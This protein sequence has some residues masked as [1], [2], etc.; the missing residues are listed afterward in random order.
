M[1]LTKTSSVWNIGD[2]TG[3][4]GRSI[5]EFDTESNASN[6]IFVRRTVL[7]RKMKYH[8]SEHYY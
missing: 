8:S 3:V 5:S 1:R 6:R 7:K 2:M 4:V